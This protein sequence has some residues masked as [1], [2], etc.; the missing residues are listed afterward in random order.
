MIAKEDIKSGARSSQLSAEPVIVGSDRH[1]FIVPVK[2]SLPGVFKSR[3]VYIPD[4]EL[5]SED[6]SVRTQGFGRYIRL[7]LTREYFLDLSEQLGSPDENGERIE[8]C[9]RAAD[10]YQ[11]AMMSIDACT[12]DQ[13]DS[14]IRQGDFPKEVIEAI[15]KTKQQKKERLEDD[16]DS[17]REDAKDADE[18]DEDKEDEDEN[19][20]FLSSPMVKSSFETC[21]A[22]T[23][24]NDAYV[25]DVMLYNEPPS[26]EAMRVFRSPSSFNYVALKDDQQGVVTNALSL[27]DFKY[28]QVFV[29]GRTAAREPTKRCVLTFVAD[30]RSSFQRP[31]HLLD[32]I[33]GVLKQ[34][35]D[36]DVSQAKEMLGQ[37]GDGDQTALHIQLM[38]MI[39]EYM[40]SELSTED[41]VAGFFYRWCATGSYR[42]ACLVVLP[43]WASV[44]PTQSVCVVRQ[45]DTTNA[46]WLGAMI[47]TA[48]ESKVTLDHPQ[49]R[50]WASFLL[51]TETMSAEA[52]QAVCNMEKQARADKNTLQTLLNRAY[53]HTGL[54]SEQRVSVP[55][56]FTD[57]IEDVRSRKDVIN[58]PMASLE[59]KEPIIGLLATEAESLCVHSN[60]ERMIFDQPNGVPVPGSSSWVPRT[61][62]QVVFGG[63]L[64]EPKS[65][66][67]VTIFHD[68]IRASGEASLP[69]RLLAIIVERT[70]D[71]DQ[72]NVAP[73]VGLFTKATAASRG[74]KATLDTDSYSLTELLAHVVVTYNAS[75]HRKKDEQLGL[76]S[77]APL[78]G[79]CFP[80]AIVFVG[81]AQ[82]GSNG[83]LESACVKINR[84]MKK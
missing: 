83:Q 79:V 74:V 35:K 52:Y 75:S 73:V 4:I 58:L 31:S 47:K 32:G 64:R 1:V 40:A 38:R 43:C 70:C 21:L 59:A 8:E 62:L 27:K 34:L 17:D 82:F 2:T 7:A 67:I 20:M 37:Y 45:G 36:A 5:T 61:Y 81:D 49:A 12:T 51:K 29:A 24:P 42:P 6:P 48:G 44:N 15:K 39:N 66:S 69:L 71:D 80:S 23:I 10:V 33:I 56:L 76:Y 57:S 55:W 22:E 72:D 19:Y 78:H 50:P 53:A 18:T 28:F 54:S 46:E 68:K 16:S 84:F 26:K 13:L 25:R 60:I 11:D 63:G 65:K 3:L 30:R 9:K 41:Q 77:Y 14:R